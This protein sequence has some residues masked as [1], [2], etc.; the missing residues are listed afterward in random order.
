MK[1]ATP[2]RRKMTRSTV[3]PP[4]EIGLLQAQ[5]VVPT[6]SVNFSEGGLCFML[7]PSITR[8]LTLVMYFNIC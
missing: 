3:P 4:F 1:T 7:E 2:E 8:E 5:T 6:T